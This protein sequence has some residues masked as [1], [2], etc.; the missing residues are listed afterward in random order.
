MGVLFSTDA[1]LTGD[2]V[3]ALVDDRRLQ[4]PDNLVPVV[5]SDVLA[6]ARV[7]TA[8]DGVSAELT[9]DGL[10]LLNWRLANAGTEPA[11]EARGWLVRHGL[12]D[13]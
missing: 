7:R 6:D 10:R 8:L 3:I 5:R 11:A 2:G 1:A 9:T 13:R 4:P 12:V